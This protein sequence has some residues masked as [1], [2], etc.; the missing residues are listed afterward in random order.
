VCVYI[1]IC[2]Y[3][4]DPRSWLPQRRRGGRRRRRRCYIFIYMCYICIYICVC[5]RIYIYMCVYVCVCVCVCVYRVNTRRR[6]RRYLSSDKS[7]C[8]C[9]HHNPDS[10]DARLFPSVVLAVAPAVAMDDAS[11]LSLPTKTKK[12]ALTLAH[13]QTI[14]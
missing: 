3:N 2:I 10:L 5:V 12:Q 9:E 11:S 6:R 7:P 14:L 8:E 13:A 4:I 1:H